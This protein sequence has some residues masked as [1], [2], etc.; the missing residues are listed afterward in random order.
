MDLGPGSLVES[1]IVH[2]FRPEHLKNISVEAD[3]EDL[4]NS[5]SL[6]YAYNQDEGEYE[7]SLGEAELKD[8]KSI[9]LFGLQSAELELEWVRDEA[10]ALAVGQRLLELAAGPGRTV[11]FEEDALTGLH[12]EKGD[13]VLYSLPWLCD[14]KG[15][16]LKNQIA[17]VLSH[18]AP[19]GQ[20][21]GALWPVGRGL[22]KDPGPSGR[23][24]PGRLGLCKGR[25]NQGQ[26]G[27]LIMSDLRTQYDDDLVGADHAT[28]EDT[29][30][31]LF[32]GGAEPVF[33]DVDGKNLAVPY[34]ATESAP[35]TGSD[36]VGL[37]A[38]ADGSETG[39]FL[40][41]ADS[42]EIIQLA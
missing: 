33:R 16:P 17:R 14:P 34:K 32:L 2:V 31:R 13:A 25:G 1:E 12:L 6:S 10:T 28:R 3:M 27:V 9:G 30:N 18:R 40:R 21:I 41:L 35:E 7:S 39:L 22:L 36:E 42:G 4:V 38:A 19:V 23:R 20:G 29:L 8:Q 11:T 15:R 26:T 24:R 5:V 37:Y